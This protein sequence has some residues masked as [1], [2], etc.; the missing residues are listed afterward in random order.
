[1]LESS[2]LPLVLH[3]AK[4]EFVCTV[5]QMHLTSH[6]RFTDRK[7][8]S[9]I[10][11]NIKGS[12]NWQFK[13]CAY[14][15]NHEVALKI[16]YINWPLCGSVSSWLFKN[17]ILWTR[18]NDDYFDNYEVS[19]KYTVLALDKCMILCQKIIFF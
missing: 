7:S 9:H 13:L 1:V 18:L 5:H 17:N 11:N 6:Q 12:I 14:I 19:I 3:L 16:L 2:Q 10:G 4:V 8:K 15:D